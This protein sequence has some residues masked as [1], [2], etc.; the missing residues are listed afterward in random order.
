MSHR[1]FIGIRPPERVSDLLL[2][3]M[4]GIE[5][6]R[7]QDE[8]NLHL[9]LRFIDEVSRPAANDLAAALERIVAAPFK[10]RIAGVGHFERKG[11]PHAVWARIAPSAPLE[12]LRQKAERA[13][14]IAGFERETRKFTPHITLARLNRSSGPAGTRRARPACCGSAGTRCATR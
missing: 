4:E 6:A 12:A 10:V 14:E 9:T 8:E 2:D 13:C 3:A 1:L 7:W 11:N 5:G